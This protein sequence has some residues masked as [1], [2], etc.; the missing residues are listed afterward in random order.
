M[1]GLV[2]N[3][4]TVVE[5]LGSGQGGI[6][7]L[8]RDAA[9]REAVIRVARDSE[10]N[11]SIRI[12]TEEAQKLVPA[13]T[14]LETPTM[15]DGR[16]VLMAMATPPPG[17]SAPPPGSGFTEHSVT[18]RLPP[19]EPVQQPTARSKASLG[20]VLLALVVFGAGA[21]M[22]VLSL[23][24]APPTIAVMAPAP[25]APPPPSPPPSAAPVAVVVPTS[26]DAAPTAAAKPT[27]KPAPTSTCIA[28]DAWRKRL[29][30][31]LSDLE[32]RSQLPLDETDREVRA[33][34]DA[35][36]AATTSQDCA[37]VDARFDALMRRALPPPRASPGPGAS[38]T[39]GVR[40]CT[41]SAQWRRGAEAD[42]RASRQ[43]IAALGDRKSFSDYEDAEDRLL[44]VANATKDGSDCR[45]LD[46]KI[47]ALLGPWR[48]RF[49]ALCPADG[50]WK[51]KARLRVLNAEALPKPKE[52]ELIDQ[53]KA[54]TDLRECL[55]VHAELASLPPPRPPAAPFD[56]TPTEEWKRMMF[57]NLEALETY[58]NQLSY[59]E[60][61]RES[62]RV[63]RLVF[64]ANTA[65]ECRLAGTEF[66][67]LRIRAIK[68]VR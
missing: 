48:K 38:E 34:H 64:N 31:D 44:Q 51:N 62:E 25:P 35:A 54:A 32:K 28:D 36:K 20:L 14:S 11:L 43:L 16:R 10:D 53:I 13:A 1:R 49:D 68:G 60:V 8:A 4:F 45:A 29:D 27:A 42:L 57:N 24:A 47:E 56:C 41:M 66:E 52:L 2:I 22:M 23:R 3:G 18:Q 61:L 67:K 6:L 55:A 5:A 17:S 7:Y 58:A 21:T 33:L 37:R 46:A 19:R 39:P 15:P 40:E 59:T 9:G 50:A 30:M 26:P 12:F 63:G 65:A